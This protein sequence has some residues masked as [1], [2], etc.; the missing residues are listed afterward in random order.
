MTHG[1]LLC[2]N[3]FCLQCSELFFFHILLTYNLHSLHIRGLPRPSGYQNVET[4][5]VPCVSSYL[6]PQASQCF[7]LDI[8]QRAFLAAA[9]D[10]NAAGLPPVPPLPRSDPAANKSSR[11]TTGPI[12]IDPAVYHG[13]NTS[14]GFSNESWPV[15]QHVMDFFW[16]ELAL[17][18][19]SPFECLTP[20]GKST[21]RARAML[22]Q[23]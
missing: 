11:L 8:D 22:T 9:K 1:M 17:S 13:S 10:R 19:G 6:A 5:A 7:V 20:D 2:L 14:S 23:H 16:G 15:G 18:E 12:V 3:A 21:V 4:D